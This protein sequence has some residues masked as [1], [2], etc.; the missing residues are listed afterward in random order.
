MSAT[1]DVLHFG[2]GQSAEIDSILVRW[3]DKS[4]QLIK[5]VLAD[6]TIVFDIKN[7]IKNKTATNTKTDS[8]KLFSPTII[9]GLQ[10]KHIEDKYTDFEREQ[11]I[12]H[13]LSAEG[14]SMAVADVNG[15]NLDDLFIGASAGQPATLYIQQING[16]FKPA[17]LEILYFDRFTEDVDAVFFDADNDGD[18]DLYLVRGGNEVAAGNPLLADRLLFN[19]G[20]GGFESRTGALPYLAL[21]GSCVRPGDL[22]GDGDLDLFLGSRSVP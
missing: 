1:S 11:L 13:S 3:P 22:D 7:A 15:D 9:Q 14:P 8:Q 19:D 18:N 12:P 6:Q 17:A 10:H 5:K 16:E 2:V 4:E 20:K 21:N